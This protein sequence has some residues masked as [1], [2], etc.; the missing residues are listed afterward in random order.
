VVD[1]L[2]TYFFGMVSGFC[3]FLA[4]LFGLILREEGYDV[5]RLFRRY[6]R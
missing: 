4:V 5:R 6:K 1:Y 3:I 2:V